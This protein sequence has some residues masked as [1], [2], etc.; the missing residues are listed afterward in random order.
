MTKD[1]EDRLQLCAELGL[2][3][4][5]QNG[6]WDGAEIERCR[7]LYSSSFGGFK[8][9]QLFYFHDICQS[10]YENLRQ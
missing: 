2:T 5:I 3:C 8:F 7:E 4:A 10:I 9:V 1:V 6:E